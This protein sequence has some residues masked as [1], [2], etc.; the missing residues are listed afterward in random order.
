MH[1]CEKGLCFR[2]GKPY[3]SLHKCAQKSL[4]VTLMA[5]DEVGE[6]FLYPINTETE[7]NTKP[8]K[9]YGTLELQLFFVSGF[10]QPQTIYEANC[11]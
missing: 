4:R 11:N 1:R 8:N 9:E 3:N 6:E 5:E 7:G 10:S 2:C